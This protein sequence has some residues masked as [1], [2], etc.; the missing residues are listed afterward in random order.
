VKYKSL[1]VSPTKKLRENFEMKGK[2]CTF[3]SE[4]NK[5]RK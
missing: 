3:A 4:N 5:E 1:S 2:D